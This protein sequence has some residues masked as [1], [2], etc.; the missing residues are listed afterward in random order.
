MANKVVYKPFSAKYREYFES[1]KDKRFCVLEGAFR[2]G[3]TSI[4]AMLFAHKLITAPPED[5]LFCLCASTIGLARLTLVDGYGLKGVFGENRVTHCKYEGNEAIRIR[6][7]ERTEKIC[8][9]VGHSL[10][11]SYSHIQGL[12][13]SG[14]WITEAALCYTSVTDDSKDFLSMAESRLTQA[15]APFII[16]DLNPASEA[17]GVYRHIEKWSKAVKPD[18]TTDYIYQQCSLYDNDA[19][20]AEQKES[21]ASLFPK[22][23]VLYAR[24]ILGKRTSAEGLIYTQYANNSSAYRVEKVDEESFL[25][26]RNIWGVSIGVDFALGGKSRYALCAVMILDNFKT[27]YVLKS[28]TYDTSDK[29]TTFV[30]DKFRE[31][32]LAVKSKYKVRSVF[33]DYAQKTLTVDLRNVCKQIAPTVAVLDS[34]KGT[35]T[36]RIALVISLIAQGRYFVSDNADTVNKSLKTAIWDNKHPDQRLDDGSVDID[37]LDAMEYAINK[38]QNKILLTK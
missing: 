16:C 17:N 31:F 4:N 29:D 32:L 8:L 5:V 14:F 22:D 6:I 15:K 20:T 27:I 23:S 33:C 12:G 11:N 2:S 36:D 18:G 35:I 7:D 37:S 34:Y 1:A 25:K 9:L 30:K 38:W 21:Y 24:N 19:L 26:G 13:I 3:K 28:V 10:S